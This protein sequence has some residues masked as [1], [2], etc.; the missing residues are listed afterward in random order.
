MAFTE[1]ILR[2]YP[3]EWNEMYFIDFAASPSNRPF[4]RNGLFFM[5]MGRFICL[6]DLK[7]E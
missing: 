5:R 4:T 1:D 7:F 6:K 2:F 3:D